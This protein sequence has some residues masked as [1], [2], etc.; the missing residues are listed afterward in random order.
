MSHTRLAATNGIMNCSASQQPS[1]VRPAR[2]Q[3]FVDAV[4]RSLR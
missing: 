1:P 3:A 4:F 2:K